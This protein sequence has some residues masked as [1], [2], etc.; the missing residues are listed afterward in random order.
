MTVSTVAAERAERA[1]KLQG[2]GAGGATV[3]HRPRCRSC[4][5]VVSRSF[6]DLGKS[7]LCETYLAAEELN[8]AEVFYPLHVWVCD[9]CR[10]VQLE[11]YVAPQDI[12]GD[13]P[14][15]SSYSTSWVR[16]AERYAEAMITRLDLGARSRVV[17]VGSNDG[18]LLQHFVARGVPAL[19]VE[20]AANVAA[21]AERR[22]VATRVAFFG[23]RTARALVEQG[24]RADLLVG[25]NVLAQVP[26]L[27]DFVEGLRVLLAPAGLITLELPHLLRTAEGNQFDQ[28]YHEHFSY[29]SLLS[30]ERVLAAHDLAV[31]D[32][33]R[34]AT[35][36]GS[37]RV[38]AVHAER[39]A[40]RVS[41]RHPG[42]RAVS[43]P[44]P[45]V[46]VA[47]AVDALRAEER[48]AGMHTADWY[49]AFEPRMRATK[50]RLLRFLIDAKDRGRSVAG[51]GAPGKGNTLLNYC[52]IGTDLLD[53]TVD[54]N[55]HKQGRF[56]PGTHVPIHAPEHVDATRPDLVLI[57]PWNLAG[58]IREQMAH[59][60]AWGGRFV[61]AIPDVRVHD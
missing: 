60:R 56:T 10:L 19:G 44:A 34:L 28:I 59:V 54:R 1:G 11:E 6:A 42:G 58:E 43:R 50:R 53:Y 7:P 17:E 46:A 4:G 12:F 22:G 23:A 3:R 27:N 31:V 49:D 33:D 40:Q 26:D 8:R 37:L 52:G 47:P 41:G 38:H 36:G 9:M 29:F 45:A 57:L 48:A 14:Y 15:F 18:Y 39:V 32:V 20:P 5:A 13:Y 55:P 24:G 2:T 51:Y 25:N 21:D 16:H 35:H 61:T 30:L